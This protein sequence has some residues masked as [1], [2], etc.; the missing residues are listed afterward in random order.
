MAEGKIL[1]FQPVTSVFSVSPLSSPGHILSP[2]NRRPP[3]QGCIARVL[4]HTPCG[5]VQRAEMKL[6]GL[7]GAEPAPSCASPAREPRAGAARP[8]CFQLAPHLRLGKCVFNNASSHTIDNN[9]QPLTQYLNLTTTPWTGLVIT[10]LILQM[11]KLSSREV[12]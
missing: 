10:L 6:L 9:C 11:R 4:S 3:A 12:K 5:S 7:E 2:S 1:L 8:L